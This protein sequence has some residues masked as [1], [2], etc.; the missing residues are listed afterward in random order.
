[1]SSTFLL[2]YKFKFEPL[3]RFRQTLLFSAACLLCLLTSRLEVSLGDSEQRVCE[4]SQTLAHREE[5]LSQLQS[6][7]QSQGLQIQQLQDTCAQL[8][9]VKEINEV[10]SS[11]SCLFLNL[12]WFFL[13]YLMIFLHVFCSFSEIPCFFRV[14]TGSPEIFK[15]LNWWKYTLK[16]FKKKSW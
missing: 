4:L 14:P 8:C 1:M 5:Q 6:L 13:Y 7:S 2:C 15:A 3:H 16:S 9:N 12:I 11:F 10:S